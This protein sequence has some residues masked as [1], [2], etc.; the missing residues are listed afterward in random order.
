MRTIKEYL[1][2]NKDHIAKR[3]KK[4]KED[5]KEHLNQMCDC[6]CGGNFSFRN[7]SRHLKSKMHINFINISPP[8]V[9]V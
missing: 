5:H 4:Y 2:D 8:I 6:E 1:E 9:N 3:G 7:R